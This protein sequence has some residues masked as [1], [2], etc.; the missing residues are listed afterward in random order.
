MTGSGSGSALSRAVIAMVIL[1]LLLLATRTARAEVERFGV[2]IGNDR[3]DSADTPL[4]YAGTDAERIRDVLQDM[5]DLPPSNVVLLRDQDAAS[6]RRALI[7]IN[8][9]IRARTGQPATEVV[10][11]VYYSGHADSTALHLGGTRLD[12]AEVEQIVRGSAAQFR[13]LLVDACRSGV[14][15][16]TKGGQVGPALSVRLGERLDGQGVV[17]LT[18]TSANEDA[19]ESDELHGSFFT[20]AFTSGLLGAAD[21]DGDGRVQLDEAYHYA[22]D[23]TLR[24]T[25]RTFAGTQHPS[26]RYEL[27]GQGRVT[28]TTLKQ[29]A[30]GTL[31]FPPDRA[32]LVIRG[33]ASGAVVAELTAKAAS[34]RLSLRPDRYF[35]RGRAPTY[36]VEGALTLAAGET[37]AVDDSVLRRVEYARLVRKGGSD[38]R[39]VHGPTAGYTFRTALRNATG[40]CHG[41]YAGYG[42]TF[43]GLSLA[44]RVDG[45][46]GG[47]DNAFVRASANELGGSVRAAHAWDVSFFT[48]DVGLSIGASWLSQRFDTLGRA[49]PRDSFAARST[50]GVG[51]A[52]PLGSGFELAAEAAGETYFFSLRGSAGEEEWAPSIAYRQRVGLTKHW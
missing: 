32:Y 52:V 38:L 43:A 29:G 13:V 31:L 10:L 40:L 20:H 35:V 42:I 12:I 4:R 23:A 45:C 5:G 18:S 1:L 11:F 39:S 21:A 49:P 33:S 51:L 46:V 34:R 17:F 50:I 7:A 27:G 26:F 37:R 41:A 24:A 28:L 9:R 47:F 48:V 22:Y 25:S 14:L 16:R 15:T 30:R 6:V 36:I 44:A 19:Q 8:D 3:G 2:F